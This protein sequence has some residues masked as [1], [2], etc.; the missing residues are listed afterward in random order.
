MQNSPISSHEDPLAR[1]VY[2]MEEYIR[3]IL[4]NDGLGAVHAQAGP[5]KMTV[6]AENNKYGG[7]RSATKTFITSDPSGAVPYDTVLM[8]KPPEAQCLLVSK[9]TSVTWIDM[10]GSRA[11]GENSWEALPDLSRPQK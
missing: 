1:R 6:P 4:Q 7:T 11:K 8:E 3:M 5:S 10:R 2:A 9:G